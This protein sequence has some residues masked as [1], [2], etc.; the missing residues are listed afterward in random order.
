MLVLVVEVQM[1]ATMLMDITHA[2]CRV[3]CKVHFFVI[4]HPSGAT[5]VSSGSCMMLQGY[6]VSLFT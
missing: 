4:R 3:L 6:V 5:A 1:M 2:R